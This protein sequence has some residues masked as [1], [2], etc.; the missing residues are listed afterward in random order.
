MGKWAVFRIKRPSGRYAWRSQ[1]PNADWDY[2]LFDT[3][4]TAINHAT[5]RAHVMLVL[6]KNK[7]EEE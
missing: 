6:T 3:Y 2:D 4:T 1:S 5:R 7:E